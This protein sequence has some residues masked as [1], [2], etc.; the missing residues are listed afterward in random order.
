M[1]EAFLKAQSSAFN[2]LPSKGS[3]LLIYDEFDNKHVNPIAYRLKNMG[4]KTVGTHLNKNIR[5]HL[6]QYMEKSSYKDIHS[7][8][9]SGQITWALVLSKNIKYKYL[10]QQI[11]LNHISYFTTLESAHL[12][13]EAM[14]KKMSMLHSNTLNPTQ[15]ISSPM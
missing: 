9:Q 10:R 2:T 13:L 7:F 6:K 5:L 3:A 12:A 14:E 11:M 4:F 8:L 1:H 15:I